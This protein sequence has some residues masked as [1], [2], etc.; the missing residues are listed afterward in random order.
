MP[1]SE[2]LVNFSRKH[3]DA[4]FVLAGLTGFALSHFLLQLVPI[5]AAS[6]SAKYGIDLVKNWLV[7]FAIA[8]F[9]SILQNGPAY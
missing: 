3:S 9:S 1:K 6:E 7:P 5:P 2:I 8:S 4:A